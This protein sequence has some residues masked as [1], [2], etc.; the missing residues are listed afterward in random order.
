MTSGNWADCDKE[1]IHIPGAIQ[2]HGALI[3]LSDDGLSVT[4]ASANAA[5]EL[6]LAQIENASLDQM[7]Q[8][9]NIKQ[10]LEEKIDHQARFISLT[11]R[12]GRT[13]RHNGL[14][15]RSPDGQLVL[16]IERVQREE[17]PIPSEKW[18][19]SSNAMQAVYRDE[20]LDVFL[21]EVC[22][23][24]R[25][26]TGY[27]RV[28]I[29]R[30]HEDLHGEVVAEEKLGKLESWLGFHY[31]ASD[32]PAQARR[33]YQLNWI[34]MIPDV[35]YTPVRVLPA[36][37]PTTGKP[38]DMTYCHLRSVS[39]VH[40]QYLKNMGAKAS[41]SLSLISPEG[42]WGMIACHHGGPRYIHYFARDMCQ[43]VAKRVS[44][45]ILRREITGRALLEEKLLELC[46]G[47]RQ[48]VL[49]AELLKD[50]IPCQRLVATG[51]LSLQ[52]AIEIDTTLADLL[53]GQEGPIFTATN[54]KGQSYPGILAVRLRQDCWLALLREEHIREV[55]WAGDPNKP[56]LG[57]SGTLRPRA[58]FM[59]W[60]DS[61]RGHSKD[62]TKLEM[63]FAS[64]M[65]MVLSGGMNVEWLRDHLSQRRDE[66]ERFATELHGPEGMSAAHKKA[67]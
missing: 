46:E 41:L 59:E 24:L 49:N 65:Q 33:L 29:Y 22:Q 36:I 40:I 43:R 18:L 16:E 54:L 44:A 20:P 53:H 4:Q 5:Q 63:E 1:P 39:P 19:R 32:I 11:A 37:S 8:S 35:D 28:M 42:L 66:A 56:V 2:P 15:H 6:R 14:L 57:E 34:R 31:P 7:F 26:L 17:G 47:F 67:G 55:R 3:V 50:L 60:R 25:E 45:A 10:L 12:A 23:E 21:R 48:R 64:L 13:I 30:F 51:E 38:L 61:V 52:G 27:D 62:W 9:R 58:S